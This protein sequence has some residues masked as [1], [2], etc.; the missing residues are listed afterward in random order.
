[1]IGSGI[2]GAW[3]EE[4]TIVSDSAIALLSGI[5]VPLIVSS[6]EGESFARKVIDTATQDPA[7]RLIEAAFA[8]TIN[9]CIDEINWK[10]PDEKISYADWAY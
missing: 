6:E 3:V 10:K 7:K 2:Y 9:K 8:A 4:K 5:G 1:M